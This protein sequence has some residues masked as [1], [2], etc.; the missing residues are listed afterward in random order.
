MAS[1]FVVRSYRCC[2]SGVRLRSSGLRARPGFGARGVLHELA[3]AAASQGV[4]GSLR[5]PN[6]PPAHP[7]EVAQLPQLRGGR[8]PRAAL[9]QRRGPQVRTGR[10]YTPTYI[11][12]AAK[13]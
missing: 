2:R 3:V 10:T 11:A 4:G 7:L 9:T 1:C 12:T 5:G 13:Y 6:Q 8:C